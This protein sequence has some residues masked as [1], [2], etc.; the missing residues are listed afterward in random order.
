MTSRLLDDDDLAATQEVEARRPA[1]RRRVRI[2]GVMGASVASFAV[3]LFAPLALASAHC[4]TTL[5]NNT[6][7]HEGQDN[8][9]NDCGTNGHPDNVIENFNGYSGDDSLNGGAGQDNIKGQSDEDLIW[10]G[11]GLQDDLEGGSGV[12]GDK[13]WG[14]NDVDKIY[15]GEDRD[16]LRG[17]EGT[18]Y[19]YDT[20]CPSPA[21]KDYVCGSG[22]HDYLYVQDGDGEDLI[23]DPGGD[24]Y[25]SYDTDLNAPGGVDVVDNYGTCPI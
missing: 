3:G 22:G 9:D 18:D 23:F 24:D 20:C 21:E 4:N 17:D 13:I 11:Y 12:G 14:G 2:R 6:H 7:W 15:G 1:G 25:Y 8:V 19:I 5:L 16:Y 10:G